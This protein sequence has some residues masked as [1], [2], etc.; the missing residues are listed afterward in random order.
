MTANDTPNGSLQGSVRHDADRSRYELVVGEDVI[1]V[2]DYDLVSE[3]AAST[4]GASGTESVNGAE[5]A[6]RHVVMHHTH[7][8][9]AHRGRG[10][11]AVVVGG[12]LDDLRKRGLRV[13][14]TC[15]YVAE[16]I[17]THP[18]YRDMLAGEARGSD[19]S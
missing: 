11:A 5:G 7:T 19:S 4:G 2:A 14:P 1:A 15:W 12:A 3:G 10:A 17:D 16:F 18:G 8:D 9:P 13:V 6:D